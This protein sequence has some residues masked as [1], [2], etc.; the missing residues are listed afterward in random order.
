MGEVS[1]STGDLLGR[2]FGREVSGSHWSWILGRGRLLKRICV[3]DR[4]E[5]SESHGDP[6][7]VEQFI[8]Q[9]GTAG[10]SSRCLFLEPKRRTKDDATRTRGSG[11]N[12]YEVGTAGIRAHLYIGMDRPD[13]QSSSKTVMLGAPERVGKA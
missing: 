1:G 13:L 7:K 6:A 12:A 2:Y 5:R 9:M 4:R 3:V 8:T 10:V 11:S